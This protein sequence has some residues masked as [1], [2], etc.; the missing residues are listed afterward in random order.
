[1]RH[2]PCNGCSSMGHDEGRRLRRGGGGLRRLAGVLS[3]V[4][5]A[6]SCGGDELAAF[7]ILHNQEP[8]AGR[9]DLA[10][11]DTEARIGAGVFDVAIGDRSSYVLT[12]LVENR[13][14]DAIVVDHALVQ[15]WMLFDDELG[16]VNIVC[17]RGELCSE[18]EIP[19]CE[20]SGCPVLPARETT[21][22]EVP[23]L[24]RLVAAW[25][26]RELDI[27]LRAG[28]APPTFELSMR[29]QLVGDRDGEQVISPV[30]DYPLDI[31]LGC[32]VT[33][34]L[35]TDSPAVPGPD[36]CGGGFPEPACYPGQDEGID[37]RRCLR[38]SPEICNFGRFS[39][40]G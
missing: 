13:T 30:F 14:S 25:I 10:T 18:W 23:V 12:P 21:S 34:P 24:P 9:C 28:R 20:G 29:V 7:E 19:L 5:G 38:T 40:A 16:P 35:G 36:C 17:D 33:F 6:A 1:M 37:C 3:F 32:L 27:A 31:C 11:V 26:V 15:V 4:L 8:T 2:G 39:C 22:F